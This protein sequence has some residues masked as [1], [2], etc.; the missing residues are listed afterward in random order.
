MQ[1]LER[2]HDSIKQDGSHIISSIYDTFCRHQR[3]KTCHD[4]FE[5]RLVSKEAR[6]DKRSKKNTCL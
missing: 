6:R 1:N 3:I 2:F 5:R 4:Y